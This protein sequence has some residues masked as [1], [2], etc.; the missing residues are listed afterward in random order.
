MDPTV[1]E[2]WKTCTLNGV[3]FGDQDY[4]GNTGGRISSIF[5]VLVT[6]LIVTM[7]PVVAAR[8]KWLR[9][10]KWV[11][12]IAKNFG[13]GVII[14][15]A[16]IHLMDPAY[17]A[18]GPQSCVGSTG[19]WA[20]YSFCPAIMLAGATMTFLI[21]T[22]CDF[23]AQKWRESRG[24][25]GP[26]HGHS[27]N[28]D[29]IILGDHETAGGEVTQNDD[30]SSSGVTVDGD[31]FVSEE[32]SS[33]TS[34]DLYAFYSQIYGFLILEFGVIF[35]SVMIGLT[36]GTTEEYSTLYI[37]IVFHQCFEGL[38]VGARLSMIP[39]PEGKRHWPFIFCVCYA[40]ATPIATAIGIGVRYSYR[41]DSFTALVVQGCLD[42]LSGGILL[43]TGFVELLARDFIFNEERTGN[44]WHL[45]AEV[46]SLLWGAG[47]M[48]LLGKWA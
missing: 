31:K 20:Q 1:D 48:A 29:N 5:V 2:S 13:S 39:F 33:Q 40:V 44:V 24:I 38:G 25:V 45:T 8:I 3:F 21:D 6:S 22:Y 12:L 30:T 11:Y 46:V 35:H 10:P 42:A 47:L 4:S 26:G 32:V 17:G 34:E 41:D 7:F 9:I 36:L 16:F 37:V 23:F 28:V 18:I 14:A 19:N 43:Y 15:T 27:H